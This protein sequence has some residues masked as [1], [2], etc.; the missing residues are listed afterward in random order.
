[1]SP[2][3]EAS[4]SFPLPFAVFEECSTFEVVVFV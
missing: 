1:M 2:R 3:F 4:P